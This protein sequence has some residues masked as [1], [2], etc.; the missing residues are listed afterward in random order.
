MEKKINPVNRKVLVPTSSPSSP[1]ILPM[2]LLFGALGSLIIGG[3]IFY[4]LYSH[5]YFSTCPTYKDKD[6]N[7]KKYDKVLP[8]DDII[9]ATLGPLSIGDGWE[10]ISDNLT[11]KYKVLSSSTINKQTKSSTNY[12]PPG[13]CLDKSELDSNY[14]DEFTKMYKKI[15]P[16][17]SPIIPPSGRKYVGSKMCFKGKNLL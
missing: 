15:V 8:T 7:V 3:I 6:Q 5:N 4:Y 12:C 1:N 11:D 13:S 2:L 9:L 17:I 16:N 14:I 10:N